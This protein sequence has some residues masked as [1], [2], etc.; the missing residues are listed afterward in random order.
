[1]SGEGCG[2]TSLSDAD[3]RRPR[4]I[5]GSS[6]TVFTHEIHE[7][8][9]LL[10]HTLRKEH[11]SLLYRVY[12]RLVYVVG[13]VRG[14]SLTHRC[15]HRRFRGR[16]LKEPVLFEDKHLLLIPVAGTPTGQPMSFDSKP[17][18]GTHVHSCYLYPLPPTLSESSG[19]GR[20]LHCSHGD[21]LRESR[22]T[23]PPPPFATGTP[24]EWRGDTVRSKH[25]NQKW[26]R[27]RHL[28]RPQIPQC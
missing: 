8:R 7:L 27:R 23:T 13:R 12:I 2:Q 3:V 22:S 6:L 21:F 18:L 20:R 19:R 28:R 15:R 10:V 4:R 24:D 5:H 14:R 17:C 9:R 25:E 1:M 11:T 16:D 26:L